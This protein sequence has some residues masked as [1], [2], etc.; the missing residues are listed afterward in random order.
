MKT[1]LTLFVQSFNDGFQVNFVGKSSDSSSRASVRQTGHAL[2][3]KYSG[4]IVLEELFTS[5]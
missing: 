4:S 3:A 2:A 5:H 1:F